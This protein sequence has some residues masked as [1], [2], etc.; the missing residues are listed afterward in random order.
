MSTPCGRRSCCEEDLARLAYDGLNAAADLAKW[1]QGRLYPATQELI[2]VIRADGVQGAVV[3]DIGAGVGAVHVSL[4]E[5]GAWSA[6]DI[7]ASHEYLATAREEAER[8]GLGDRVTYQ[9]GDVVQ[10]RDQLPAADI[11]TL[12]SVICCNPDL[13]SLLEVATRSQPRLVGLTYPRDVWWMRTYMRLYNLVQA[14]RRIQA[15]YFIHRHDAV[16][17][18]MSSAGYRNAHEGGTREWR[19]VVYARTQP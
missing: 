2:D 5:A 19:V 3:L 6:I 7:D 14:V 15:R 11:V 17:R 13:E 4:L 18:W 10:L 12:D 1:H 9:Y 16:E 8:R